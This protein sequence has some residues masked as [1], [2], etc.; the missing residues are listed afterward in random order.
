MLFQSTFPRGERRYARYN[1]ADGTQISIHVP[2]WGTTVYKYSYAMTIAISIHVPAWGTT[3]I[4]H[5]RHL[6]LVISIHVPAWGTTRFLQLLFNWFV[7][8]STFPRGERRSYLFR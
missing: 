3:V 7:F 2:A 6:H 5:L 4:H 1:E 8:Q